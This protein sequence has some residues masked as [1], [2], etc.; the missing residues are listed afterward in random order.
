MKG[1]N[2]HTGRMLDIHINRLW[3]LPYVLVLVGFGFVL[4]HGYPMAIAIS[5]TVV[6]SYS[7]L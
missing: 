2:P 5:A 1:W 4:N 7:C 6:W 3:A